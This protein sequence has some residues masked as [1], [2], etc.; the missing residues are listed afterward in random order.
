MY[1]DRSDIKTEN[2]NNIS[3]NQ[4][5]LEFL[6]LL[7]TLAPSAHNTQPWLFKITNNSITVLANFD[8][9]LEYSDHNHRQLFI[10]V[11]AAIANLEVASKAY[12][13]DF[14]F[15]IFPQPKDNEVAVFKFNDLESNQ[16]DSVSLQNLVNRKSNRLPLN[17]E[18]ISHEVL[19]Q[20]TSSVKSPV[21][22]DFISDDIRKEELQKIVADSVEEAFSDSKFTDEL[23]HWIKPSSVKYRDGMPGYTIGVPKLISYFLPF[24]IKHFD[25]RAFQ[26]RMH[27]EWLNNAPIY[28][29]VSSEKDEPYSW[30]M[31]G[32]YFEQMALASEA[33]GI[34][35]GIMGGPVEIGTHYLNI[36]KVIGTT[37]RPQMFFRIGYGPD[38]PNF[39]PRINYKETIIS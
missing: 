6:V 13:L 21:K 10:S 17:K 30:M 16:V 36:Q 15:E 23:S 26:K 1:N 11:G 38:M 2:Y 27:R 20:I 19:N 12:S 7:A 39:S 28:G 34:R 37:N 31:S 4:G 18:I 3:T 33:K 32:Y 24:A 25:L 9:E 35:I 8:R 14:N 22:I 5:K 29:V